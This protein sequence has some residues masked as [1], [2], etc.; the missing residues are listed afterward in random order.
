MSILTEVPIP[1]LCFDVH[2]VSQRASA[3]LV[4][5]K[6]SISG[7][8]GKNGSRG[9]DGASGTPGKDGS[10]G[11]HGGRGST[12]EDGSAGEVSQSGTDSQHAI[13]QLNGTVENLNMQLKMCDILHDSSRQVF[14][15]NPNLT[16]WLNDVNYN[17]QLA[18][19]KGIILVQAVGGN[20]GNGGV[21]GNGGDGG[22]GG[23]GGDG[24][25]GKDGS[26][27]Y[28]QG[29]TG[30]RGGVGG[31]GGNGGCGG[32]GGNGGTGGNGGNAG[33]G[34]HIVEGGIKG[35]ADLGG[36][37]GS[38]GVGGRGGNGGHGGSGG[39]GGPGGSDGTD[40][41]EGPPGKRGS[42]GRAGTNGPTGN[43]G[44]AASDGHIEYAV[45]DVDDKIIEIDP[46]KYHASVLG[47][48]I[49]DEN[50]DEIYEPDSDFFITDVKWTNNGAMSLP[51]GSIL[52]FPSTKYI[53]SDITDVSTLVGANINQILI[54]SHRFKC[55]LNA[56]PTVSINQPYI[57]PVKL[58]SEINLLGR[59]FTHSQVSI[60]LTCQ[61]PVQ[62]RN[63]QITTFLGPNERAIIVLDFANI[64]TRPYVTCAGSA[65]S[66]EF[67]FY[68]HSL[69]KLLPATTENSYCITPNGHGRYK[70]NEELSPKCTKTI[71]F[72]F[73]LN[74]DASYQLYENL[75]WNVDLLLRDRL[76]ENHTG[77]IRIVPEFNPNIKTD[78][79]LVTNSQTN[80]VEYLA[81][82]KLFQLFKYSSQMWD[83]ERYQT[84]HHPEIQWLATANLIIFIY[85]NP[86]STF[87]VIK[88]Q[89]FLQHMNSSENAG[90]ICIGNCLP[91]D[92]D[93]ALFDY[94]NSQ[95][96]DNK[97]KTKSEFSNHLWS[98]F[99]CKQ[100]D[101]EI[102]N[103]M[104]NKLRTDYEKRE[105]HKFLYQTVY[106]DTT[107]VCS[108]H[109]MTVVYGTKY[110]YKS[111][112]DFQV[113]NRLI[114]INSE[115]PLLAISHLPFK[116]QTRLN[117]NQLNELISSHE[118]EIGIN[119]IDNTAQLEE[120]IIQ[121]K[122]HLDS[123]LARL[124]CA[125]LFYQGFEKSLMMISE[126]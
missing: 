38:Y 85:L 31:A 72:E 111:T 94:N 122:I 25:D 7:Q 30:K 35:K 121:D 75:F 32:N 77:Y 87:N 51:S 23:K 67:I 14:D 42:Y 102:L 18:K 101:G 90:F 24:C 57:Q 70:I 9:S 47:Y 61:Y 74:A 36:K 50:N 20:G 3:K 53:S 6:I 115:S 26:K 17:F 40:S 45:V 41:A 78:V 83:I 28:N 49:T 105:D 91:N 112:L 104:A 126:K 4:H 68:A 109:C 73:C 58:V 65:G 21:G 120:S 116:V 54:D 108:Q 99:G 79:L 19:S 119:E 46:D 29:A 37:G 48:T 123:Q 44:C 22:P 1:N 103:A 69:I 100:P 96:I 11:G 63:I 113:G 106:D 27:S 2:S 16:H 93:F 86:K 13:V 66:I 55:Y 88:S 92:F 114:L 64:S 39:R 52:S 84:F 34:G 15:I 5:Q 110:V 107:D 89:L 98:G 59:L 71:C 43:V 33:A 62:I 8:S 81:Y 10:T 80:R 95:F 60:T 97:H 124:L 82:Q 12:G 76:I 125:I 117:R 118:Y 56:V